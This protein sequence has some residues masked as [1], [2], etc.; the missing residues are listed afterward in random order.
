MYPLNLLKEFRPVYTA[1]RIDIE[2]QPQEKEIQVEEEKGGLEKSHY[3][4]K[5]S[6]KGNSLEISHLKS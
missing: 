4:I 3:T 6:K 2:E 5:K 1:D